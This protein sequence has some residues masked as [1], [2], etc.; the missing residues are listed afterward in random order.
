MAFYLNV[1]LSVMLSFGCLQATVSP[2]EK[3]PDKVVQTV[4][5]EMPECGCCVIRDAPVNLSHQANLFPEKTDVERVLIRGVMFESDGKTPAKNAVMY[6][7][8]TD[9]TGRYTKRGDEPRNSFAWWHGKQRGW[10]KTNERGEYEINTVKPAPYPSRDEP[11]HIH[12]IVKSPAQ[13]HCYN[14][15]DFVFQDDELLTAKFWDNT[16]NWWRSIGIYQNPNYG[17]VRLTKNNGGFQQ[18]VR[19]I[20]LFPEIDAPKID[21]GRGIL[22]ESPAF[23]PQHAWGADKGSHACPMCKYG[24]QPG[25][26]FWVNS[27]ANPQQVEKWAKWLEDLSVLLGDKNFK[28]YLIYTNPRKLSR[29]QL[30]TKLAAF[31]QKLNLKK[32]AV[33]YVP[34]AD[35]KATDTYLNRINPATENTFIVYNNRKVA[36]KFVNF[37]F[38]EQN[39]TLLR[40]SVERAGKEK[41][42]Y[43]DKQ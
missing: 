2:A 10:L 6:F 43:A 8:H 27:D 16:K 23:E 15:A 32:I 41:E 14:I 26:L 28:A 40:A 31:G 24:Y 34:S 38:N 5:S 22:E 29:A 9:E 30:E 11:A 4:Q 7:Y 1:L 37:E 17:G 39:T 12:A 19:N 33:T 36:D 35:D 42:L 21:S 3:T 25:V 20:T 13:K 18:G